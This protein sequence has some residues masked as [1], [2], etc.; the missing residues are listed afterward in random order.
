MCNLSV[1]SGMNSCNINKCHILSFHSYAGKQLMKSSL[2][3]SSN[4]DCNYTVI[5]YNMFTHSD[6]ISHFIYAYMVAINE[7]NIIL[8]Y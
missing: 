6:A 1:V 7:Y 5:S 4:H 2:Q 8:Q 3:L